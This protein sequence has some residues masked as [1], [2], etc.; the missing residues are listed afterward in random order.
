MVVKETMNL[1][2]QESYACRAILNNEQQ[3]TYGTIMD[4]VKLESGGTF[5][6]DDPD[7]AGK[8]FLYKT[9]LVGLRS[10]NNCF[11]NCIPCSICIFITRRSNS[12]FKI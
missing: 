4:K 6:I 9:L 1:D 8:T 12:S 5:F 2:I 11:D 10:Q 7:E 3:F